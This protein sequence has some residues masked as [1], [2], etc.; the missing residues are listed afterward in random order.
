M[1]QTLVALMALSLVAGC[2]RADTKTEK[3][4]KFEGWLTDYKAAG[5]V[6]SEGTKPILVYF[7]GTDW[8]GWCKK[9]E[10]EVL[11]KKEFKA[12]AT[13]NLVRFLADFPAKTKQSKELKRQNSALAKKYKVQGFPT[14][15]LLDA[16]G[17]L[18]ATTGYRP[19]GAK[20]Y[21]EH[22]KGLVKKQKH[23]K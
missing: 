2:A 4:D 6:A 20:K 21:V 16:K 8:C 12:Y 9:L 3:T 19:G 22:L 17:K 13:K 15:L 10:K 23:A 18:L 5:D 1:K 11:S 7:A 14:L